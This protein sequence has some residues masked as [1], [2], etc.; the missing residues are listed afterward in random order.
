MNSILSIFRR[1]HRGFT[2]VET[3]MAVTV[4]GLAAVG[5]VAFLRQG[6]LMYYNDRARTMINR[7]IRSFTTQMDT[8]AVTANLF[9]LY[10]NFTT[11]VD[12]PI[13]SG[14][15]GDFLILVYTD[16]SQT[17]Y[18]VSMITQLVGYYREVTNTQLNY[19][20]VHRFVID[21]SAAPI[22]IKSAPMATIV[23]NVVTGSASSYPIVT[24]LAQGL[25][26][27]T[28]TGTQP[29]PA[30][31]YNFGNNSVMIDA[32]ISESLTEVGTT[33][34]TGNTYNFTVSPRG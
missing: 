2:L 15:V 6:M 12:P 9:V 14:G 25:A 24:Q 22:N 1:G 11:R 20:P 21:L 26:T 16:P 13:R 29:T 23:N 32:Q 19:G 3:L 4:M 18:G 34:Q 10:Q 33:S 5:I 8:D 7:D 17:S 27:S 28:L 31:F 30:L